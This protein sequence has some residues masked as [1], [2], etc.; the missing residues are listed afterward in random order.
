MRDFSAGH[1]H[2]IDAE[3]ELVGESLMP[4]IFEA[5]YNLDF[6][7]DEMLRT[8]GNVG[9][10]ELSLGPS[11]HR[12]VILPGI[13][14]MPLA[15]LEKLEA[16]V[17]DGGILIATRRLPE[18]APGL[19]VTAAEQA[20]L[21][22]GV[23][24]IFD[25]SRKAVFIERDEDIGAALKKLLPP[26]ADI[27]PSGRDFGFVHRKTSDGELYFVANTS[28]QKKSVRITFRAAVGRPAILDAMTGQV[29]RRGRN[30][31]SGWSG[32]WLWIS[33]RTSRT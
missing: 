22:A 15:T 20:R 27:S 11:R 13:E 12:V 32:R 9:K 16:F 26:D 8:I 18:I 4:A 17:N 5:G 30:K 19:G 28:N 23:K 14:R 3:R 33:S 29:L 2:L 21:T 10:G 31:R 25:G 1:V 7:D 24:R 6:F